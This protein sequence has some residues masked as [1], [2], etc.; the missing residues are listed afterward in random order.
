MLGIILF[1][2]G[3]IIDLSFSNG[4]KSKS[5]AITGSDAFPF[6]LNQ[7]KSKVAKIDLYRFNQQMAEA[8]GAMTGKERVSQNLNT[9]FVDIHKVFAH[10]GKKK[11][12]GH[13]D[14]KFSDGKLIAYVFF[15]NGK[16]VDCFFFSKESRNT[17]SGLQI[18]N[19]VIQH[20]A[21]VGA[22]LN[23]YRRLGQPKT[24]EVSSVAHPPREKV[25]DF[26]QFGFQL[27][28]TKLRKRLGESKF[29]QFFTDAC[30]ALT[31]R[32]PFMHPFAG[33]VSC[34]NGNL[35]IDPEA[36]LTEV[37]QAINGCLDHAFK[38]IAAEQFDP[39]PMIR[40]EIKQAWDSQFQD[41]G[42][43]QIHLA[44]PVLFEGN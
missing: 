5:D 26:L 22:S 30:I 24:M 15:Q 43:W 34:A 14:M 6:I 31:D 42:A 33:M 12:T 3:R 21:K 32:Y 13:M 20:A 38:A 40:P 2:Q 17:H 11:F 37:L 23:I 7:S 8:F 4:Y 9:D 25:I 35:S 16:P 39:L 1:R 19:H 10:L 41:L 36:D 27:I 18:L 44:L 29:E 28:Y